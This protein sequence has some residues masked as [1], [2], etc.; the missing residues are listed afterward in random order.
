MSHVR[1][2]LGSG[3]GEVWLTGEPEQFQGVVTSA[4]GLTFGAE[5]KMT[6]EAGPGWVAQ[7]PMD[8]RQR[9]VTMSF[10]VTRSFVS[11]VA[12]AAWL[13][14]LLSAEPS[15]ASQADVYVRWYHNTEIGYTQSKL[16]WAAVRYDSIAHD[17]PRTLRMRISIM[18]AEM[19]DNEVYAQQHL[20]AETGPRFLLED[21]TPIRISD[22]YVL[23]TVDD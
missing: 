6:V 15:V 22:N 5:Q 18:S 3:V 13:A 4:G 21:G 19:L 9:G 12:M 7:R 10:W 11:V 20:L 16:P 1:V 2:R 17:G 8:L 14:D 23:V